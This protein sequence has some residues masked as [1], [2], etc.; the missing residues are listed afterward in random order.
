M[1]FVPDSDAQINQIYLD[2][3]ELDYYKNY[4][5]AEAGE[6]NFHPTLLHWTVHPDRDDDWFDETTRTAISQVH[7]LSMSGGTD[8][9]TYRASLNYRDADGISLNTGFNQLNAR[10]NLTQKAL[11]DRL[12]LNLNLSATHTEAQLGF[13]AAFRYA[14][15]YNPTAPVKSDDAAYDMYDGYFNQVLFDYYNPVQIL[16]Q[17]ITL[18]PML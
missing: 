16:E 18:K 12:T 15:I 3:I 14:T 10:L 6:N 4:V 5:A 17:N 2:W 1:V 13:E 7:N 11:N 8:K 9:T